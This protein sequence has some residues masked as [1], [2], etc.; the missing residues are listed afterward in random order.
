MTT[1]Y[2]N[3]NKNNKASVDTKSKNPPLKRPHCIS[4]TTFVVIDET[5]V[6]RLRIKEENTWLEQ[7]QTENDDGIL[8]KI[9]RFS[10]VNNEE[11]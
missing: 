2:D 4:N 3:T 7:V 8:M 5:L 6:K 9:R 10:S 1:V 11:S